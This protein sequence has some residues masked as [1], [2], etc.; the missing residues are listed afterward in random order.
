[1]NTMI[2][3]TKTASFK[4]F[5]GIAPGSKEVSL[6]IAKNNKEIRDFSRSLDEA[7]FE[8]AEGVFDLFRFPKA[9]MTVSE[10]MD[11]DVYDFIVQYPTGQI[12]IFDKKLMRSQTLS[13]DYKNSAIVLLVE[14]N[15]LN[16]IQE[17]GFDLLSAT[18]PALQL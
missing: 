1:M 8:Q 10:D 16:K 14:K 15:N 7:G 5:L 4:E 12:E 6:A 13:P 18:G 9:Y 17:K 2:S 11:K 3:Q